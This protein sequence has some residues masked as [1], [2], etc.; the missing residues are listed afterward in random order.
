MKHPYEKFIRIELLALLSVVFL[1]IIAFIK[2]WVFLVVVS[3][4]FIVFSLIAHAL[5]EW[6]THQ[7]ALAGK[8]LVRALFIFLLT[9]YLL[10]HI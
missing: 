8:Q 4:F 3:L 5:A 2:A 7:R 9:I 6:H 1:S 10:F